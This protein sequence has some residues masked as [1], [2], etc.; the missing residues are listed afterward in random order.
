[1]TGKKILIIAGTRPEL[2][3]LAPVV[4]TARTSG[5]DVTFMI[6]GQ[7]KEMA[8]QVLTTFGVKA[9]ADLDI[10]LPG[11]NLAQLTSRLID[12]LSVSLQELKPDMVVVQGDTTS[13]A[14][15]GLMAFYERIPVAHVEAGLR[16][17]NNFHPFPEEVNRKIVSTYSTLNFPPTA[18]S[19]ANLLAENV[20]ANTILVTGNT[21]V[22][23]AELIK[24]KLPAPNKQTGQRQILV[25]THRRENWN[26]EIENICRALVTL[27]NRYPDLS[28]HLPVH[29]NPIVS[30]QI[31][32][33]L[34]NTAR[35][36]LCEPLD[37]IDL[38]AALRDSYLVLTDSGGIQEEAP[39]YG[40][41]SLVLREVTERPEAVQAGVAKIIG[42]QEQRIITEVSLL[43][44]DQSAYQ[45]MARA[46]NPFGDGKAAQRIVQAINLYL[47]G[48]LPALRNVE[49]FSGS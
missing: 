39:I 36:K 11:S 45:L 21:V 30:K 34:G 43:L 33:L 32:A 47:E 6:T 49:E 25:T 48:G 40:V 28:V 8:Q 31:H 1:M 15:G 22:D 10:M 4:E 35:V 20:S 38:Q 19:K 12:K 41:P 5:A 9:D 17:N 18:L 14:I 23:A 2:I 7:H 29:R 26:N 37:Y 24:K 16:S 46:T 42:T 3:K 13:A 27:V 44:D